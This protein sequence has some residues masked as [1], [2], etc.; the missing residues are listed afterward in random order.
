MAVLDSVETAVSIFKLKT[1]N[2]LAYMDY[3]EFL[4]HLLARFCDIF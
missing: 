3:I 4:E 2:S 1:R